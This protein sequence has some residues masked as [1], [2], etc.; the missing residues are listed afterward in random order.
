MKSSI[1]NT[2][3]LTVMILSA[4]SQASSDAKVTRPNSPVVVPDGLPF[5]EY[6][7]VGNMIYLSGQIG[8]SPGTLKVVDGGLEAETRQTLDN[9]KAVLESQGHSLKDI[10]KCTIMMDDI[11]QWAAFNKVYSTYFTDNYPAR[12]AFGADGLG[13][14]AAVEIDCIAVANQN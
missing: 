3:L 11:T 7:Q 6:V 9:I 13:L 1:K 8:I 2:L 12:S 14:G 10:I 5:S 4:C